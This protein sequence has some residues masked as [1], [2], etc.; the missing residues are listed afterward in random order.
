MIR[1]PIQ[2]A[3]ISE[4]RRREAALLTIQDQLETLKLDEE[5]DQEEMEGRLAYNAFPVENPLEK[6]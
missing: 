2:Y 1:H 6:E 3:A 5:M 4:L